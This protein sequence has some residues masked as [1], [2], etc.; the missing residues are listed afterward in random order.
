MFLAGRQR[1]HLW[2][3]WLSVPSPRPG[4]TAGSMALGLRVLRGP[5]RPLASLQAKSLPEF[6]DLCS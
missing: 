3:R 5:H 2:L 6:P 1:E 4:P